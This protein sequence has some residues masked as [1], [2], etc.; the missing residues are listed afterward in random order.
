MITLLC[1]FQSMN[2]F[3]I[4][5]AYCSTPSIVYCTRVFFWRFSDTIVV[6][7]NIYTTL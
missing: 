7:R 6:V 2:I 5:K 3:C 1:L 4:A